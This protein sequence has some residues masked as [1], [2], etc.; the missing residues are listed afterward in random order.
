MIAQGETKKE[1]LSY[2]KISN[3]VKLVGLA[4][5]PFLNETSEDKAVFQIEPEEWDQFC[6]GLYSCRST[7]LRNDATTLQLPILQKALDKEGDGDVLSKGKE[8]STINEELA[9]NTI[10]N[11]DFYDTVMLCLVQQAISI[12]SPYLYGNQALSQETVE[13]AL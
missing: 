10:F 9:A 11:T 6:Q 8:D 2:G 13:S 7:L 5:T 1:L 4:C 3:L 12:I